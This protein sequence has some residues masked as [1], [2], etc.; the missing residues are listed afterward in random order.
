[1]NAEERSALVVRLERKMIGEDPDST[2]VV[3]ASRYRMAVEQ[4]ADWIAAVE[5]LGYQTV[6]KACG[7]TAA[8]GQLTCNLPT[9]HAADHAEYG[10]Q[11]EWEDWECDGVPDAK[12]SEPE[13]EPE[14]RPTVVDL[15]DNLERS[16]AAA[17]RSPR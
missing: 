12:P 17:K 3:G 15:M 9:G 13:P 14:P 1:M 4:A 6:P 2:S 8:Y 11:V 10:V 5:D 16:L 7:R